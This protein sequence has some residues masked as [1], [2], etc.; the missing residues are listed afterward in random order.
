MAKMNEGPD[1]QHI[2]Q[3]TKAKFRQM[4]SSLL[5]TSSI[6]SSK[7]K[8]HKLRQ[9]QND[10]NNQRGSPSALLTSNRLNIEQKTSDNIPNKV[11]SNIQELKH[12]ARKLDQEQ[13]IKL[14]KENAQLP[15]IESKEIE[16]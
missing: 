1:C 16:K 15:E 9:E 3:Q 10:N 4:A 12:L 11:F 6:F 5:L 8:V 13:I 7:Q 2:M 14:G